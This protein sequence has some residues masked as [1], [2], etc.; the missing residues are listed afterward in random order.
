MNWLDR[1]TEIHCQEE[2]QREAEIRGRG[3]TRLEGQI[4]GRREWDGLCVGS[5]EFCTNG[6]QNDNF[7]GFVRV[8]FTDDASTYIE[9]SVD[10]AKSQQVHVVAITFRGDAEIHAFVESIEFLAK[11]LRAALSVSS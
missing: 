4:S 8:A 2:L 3:K 1:D 7:D 6:P 11:K 10:G 5:V 9:V